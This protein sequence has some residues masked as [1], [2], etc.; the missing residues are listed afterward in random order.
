MFAAIRVSPMRGRC[1][2]SVGGLL[3]EHTTQ[4]AIDQERGSAEVGFPNEMGIKSLVR[5][6]S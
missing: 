2:G 6:V 4:E 1:R 3:L 5:L